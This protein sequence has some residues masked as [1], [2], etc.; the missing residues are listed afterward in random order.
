PADGIR[1]ALQDD[2]RIVSRHI[3]PTALH[4][5]IPE[6]PGRVRRH[7]PVALHRSWQLNHLPAHEF[8]PLALVLRALGPVIELFR[9]HPLGCGRAPPCTWTAPRC[10]LEWGRQPSTPRSRLRAKASAP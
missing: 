5:V 1:V 6:D 4:R 8:K 9:G 10:G 7:D 2:A 3:A